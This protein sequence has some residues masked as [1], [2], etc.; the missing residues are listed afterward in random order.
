MCRP[1][2]PKRSNG[3]SIGGGVRWRVDGKKLFS[4]ID[5]GPFYCYQYPMQTKNLFQSKTI[6]FNTLTA[7]SV[8]VP[9]V[10]GF[11]TKQPEIVVGAVALANLLLRL[12]TSKKIQLFPED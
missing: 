7:L 9:S 10:G 11:V 4:D 2:W 12:T 6:I 1:I 5:S 8:L 3:L